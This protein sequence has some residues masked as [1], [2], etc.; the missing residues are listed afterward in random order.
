MALL[1][2]VSFSACIVGDG[3]DVGDTSRIQEGIVRSLSTE[4]AGHFDIVG[5]YEVNCIGRRD[6]TIVY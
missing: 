6:G 3:L 2:E 5:V 1:I 4:D